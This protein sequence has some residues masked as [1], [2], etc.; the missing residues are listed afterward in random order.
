MSKSCQLFS[1]IFYVVFISMTVSD[2]H[3]GKDEEQQTSLEE[4]LAFIEGGDGEENEQ[5]VTSKVSKRQK[6]KQK[7][8]W[9]VLL[10]KSSP[11][12]FLRLQLSNKLIINVAVS[13][14]VCCCQF[15][16]EQSL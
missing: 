9:F 14:Y 6:K 16:Y 7:K 4:L 10:L 2:L 13:S 11:S 8:V 15:F 12:I 5:V 3:S 1:E